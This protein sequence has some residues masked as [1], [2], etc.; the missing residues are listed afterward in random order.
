[1]ATAEDVKQ[2]VSVIDGGNEDEVVEDQLDQLKKQYDTICEMW[3][4]YRTECDRIINAEEKIEEDGVMDNSW[5]RIERKFDNI[6]ELWRL[7]KQY[8]EMVTEY[9]IEYR[10]YQDN[11]KATIM[12]MTA[13]SEEVLQHQEQQS[14]HNN[15]TENIGLKSNIND[16]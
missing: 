12:N 14:S 10:K 2:T 11:M 8:N 5:D 4:E 9:N 6:C 15:D 7:K 1:M 3:V 13:K 16:N